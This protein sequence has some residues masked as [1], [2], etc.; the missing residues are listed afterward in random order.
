MHEEKA[1]LHYPDPPGC[2]TPPYQRG[3]KGG[4]SIPEVNN[5]AC[6]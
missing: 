6:H 3:D 2:A 5:N 4:I 1:M